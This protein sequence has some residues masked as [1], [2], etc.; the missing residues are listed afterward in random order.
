MTDLLVT[1]AARFYRVADI[2]LIKF[3]S[4]KKILY[5]KYPSSDYLQYNLITADF[6]M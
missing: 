4:Y 6:A 1:L 2:I 5:F 3:G